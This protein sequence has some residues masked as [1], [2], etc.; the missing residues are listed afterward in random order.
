MTKNKQKPALQV[1]HLS[2]RVDSHNVSADVAMNIFLKVNSHADVPPDGLVFEHTTN[3]VIKGTCI[4]PTSRESELF[5]ISIHG[6]E[7][8]SME[9]RIKDIQE[10]DEK[11]SPIYRQERGKRVP[12]YRQI[13]GIA[14]LDR[15][16]DG[17]IWHVWVGVNP[18]L[19]TDMLILLGRTQPLY[20]AIDETKADRRRWVQGLAL[21]TTDPSKEE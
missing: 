21:Q 4:A 3:I 7:S 20:I 2:I 18:R 9:T 6:D 17:G 19:V 8:P 11:Y 12:V 10:R 13:P 5:E 14:V 15:R 1:T 16:R